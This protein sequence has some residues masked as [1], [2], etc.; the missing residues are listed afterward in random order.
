MG[1]N[2]F[3]GSKY[4]VGGIWVWIAKILFCVGGSLSDLVSQF[5]DMAAMIHI[6]NSRYYTHVMDC[7]L[8]YKFQAYH[9]V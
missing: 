3:H 8:F 2:D 4:N 1:Q 7:L 6:N 5:R 9:I